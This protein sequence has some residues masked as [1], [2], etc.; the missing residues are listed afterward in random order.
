MDRPKCV[1]VQG[2][3]SGMYGY[4]IQL[5][6]IRTVRMYKSV[7]SRGR[8]ARGS[9]RRNRRRAGGDGCEKPSR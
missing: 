9:W 4:V 8:E 5:C 1:Y 3:T 6:F 7:G 2:P